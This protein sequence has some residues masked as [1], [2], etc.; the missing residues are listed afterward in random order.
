MA[1][2]LAPRPGAITLPRSLFVVAGA[3]YLVVAVVLERRG[4][5]FGDALARV[6]NAYG[7]IFSR[8][9]HL[10]AIGFVWNPLPSV[11]AMPFLLVKGWFPSL[12]SAG[13]AG[14]IVSALAMAAAVALTYRVATR[15][16]DSR[17]VGVIAA[18]GVALHPMIALYAGNGMSEALLIATLLLCVDQ[19][20]VWLDSGRTRSLAFAG[21]GLALAYLC[22]YEAVAAAA[23]TA[24][25]VAVVSYRRSS[26]DPRRRRMAMATDL[27]IYAFPFVLA[28]VLWAAIA[29]VIVGE[30]FPIFTSVYGNSNQVALSAGGIALATA[31][32]GGR[33]AYFRAQLLGLAPL[34][35]VA[36]AVIALA[37]VRARR[38]A[39]L[40]APACLGA[41]L[42]FQAASLFAG[43][44]FGWLRFAITAVPLTALGAASARDAL[45][46]VGRRVTLFVAAIATV[47]VVAS[48]LPLAAHTVLDRRLAREESAMVRAAVVPHDATPDDRLSLTRTRHY[49]RIASAL[50]DLRLGEGQIIADAAFAFPIILASQRPTQFVATPDRDFEMIANN[51]QS[52]RTRYALVPDPHS[53]SFDYLARGW[54]Q[55]FA[56]G[57]GPDGRWT[58]V[59]EFPGASV[60]STWRLYKLA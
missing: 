37:A 12:A 21:A 27:T 47:V 46:G 56:S 8:D 53:A 59:R 3:A 48:S 57:Q 45:R 31:G 28:F 6:G 10:A 41:V 15:L 16:G 50:D 49:G 39:V 35:P 2:E 33:L 17:I 9:P 11:L 19:L 13:F 20:V 58:I 26:G 54:P 36:A 7:V 34:L 25:L 30:P 55:F 23:G 24:A 44:T 52:F 40:A 4:V 51:P 18:V 32:P 60:A 29:W 14:A 42:A 5:L 1:L 38:A 22:R 43:M